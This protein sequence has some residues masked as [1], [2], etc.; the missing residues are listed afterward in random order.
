[1]IKALNDY[2]IFKLREDNNGLLLKINSEKNI[3]VVIS[4]NVLDIGNIIIFDD[5]KVKTFIY[6]NNEY[7]VIDIKDVYGVIKE[8]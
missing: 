1:M 4:S 3:G 6:E 5:T 7:L 2:V 8:G